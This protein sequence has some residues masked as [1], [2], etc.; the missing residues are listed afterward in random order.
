MSLNPRD[1]D[2]DE[3]RRAADEELGGR[4]LRELRER[5]AE[6]EP[7]ADAAKALRSDQ[8]KEL[9][10]LESG[11]QPEDLERPY[12]DALP[13]AYAARLMLFEWLDFL[14]QRG[15]VRQTLEAL[16]YYADLG[17]ISSSV[18]ENLRDHVRAFDTLPDEAELMPLEVAD[19]ILSLVYVARLASMG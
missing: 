16:D 5:I 9:L 18:A 8:I 3:L 2:P 14:L 11:A 7:S 1:Y 6:T 15:G 17:W 19:H 10:L 13:D 4:N 12:L